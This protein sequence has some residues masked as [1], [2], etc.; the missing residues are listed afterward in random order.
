MFSVCSVAM[1]SAESGYNK[2]TF[3]TDN[4]VFSMTQLPVKNILIKLN[5]TKN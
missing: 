3:I 5:S 2:M 1:G 4:V